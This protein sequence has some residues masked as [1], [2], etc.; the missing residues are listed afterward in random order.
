MFYRF[1][2][3]SEIDYGNNC[4]NVGLELKTKAFFLGEN[5]ERENFL[6][7]TKLYRLLN[8]IL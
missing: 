1:L 6:E 5:E 7:S 8:Q 4:G 3:H 2:Y